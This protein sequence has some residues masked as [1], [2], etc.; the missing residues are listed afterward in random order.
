MSIFKTTVFWAKLA[1][2]Q[3]YYNYSE[4]PLAFKDGVIP[5]YSCKV[6]Q[7]QRH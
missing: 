3:T 6:V 5:N 1:P 2:F 7:I 4:H